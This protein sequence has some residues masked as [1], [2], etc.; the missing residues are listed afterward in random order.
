MDDWDP[1]FVVSTLSTN[2]RG[3]RITLNQVRQAD[4]ADQDHQVDQRRTNP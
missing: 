1:R 2:T 4:R 3:D